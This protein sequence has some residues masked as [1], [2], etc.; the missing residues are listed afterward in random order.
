MLA[1]RPK[2]KHV[3]HFAVNCCQMLSNAVSYDV[4]MVGPAVDLLEMLLETCWQTAVIRCRRCPC[5]KHSE[6]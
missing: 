2:E 3:A 5:S 6:N 4:K 1:A